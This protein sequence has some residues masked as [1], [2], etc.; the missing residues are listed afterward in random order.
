LSS[1]SHPLGSV[2]PPPPLPSPPSSPSPP[3][4]GPP[5]GEDS[6]AGRRSS[7]PFLTSYPAASARPRGRRLAEKDPG[8]HRPTTAATG[9]GDWGMIQSPLQRLWR[10]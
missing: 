7:C 5:P 10:I 9:R 4:G 1:P 8:G 3:P 2:A 6:L